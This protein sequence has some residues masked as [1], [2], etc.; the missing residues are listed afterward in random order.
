MAKTSTTICRILVLVK[1]AMYLKKRVYQ[2]GC[3][4]VRWG[5]GSPC[6]PAVTRLGT[7]ARCAPR[8]TP[9]NP[10]SCS[11][12]PHMKILLDLVSMATPPYVLV[13]CKAWQGV[14]R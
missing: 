8:H 1:L 14:G 12:A 7:S 10:F 5:Q 9:P 2:E 13:A 4:G 6:P 3:G 11:P